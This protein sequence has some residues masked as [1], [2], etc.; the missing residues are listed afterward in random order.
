MSDI[1]EQIGPYKVGREI[2]RGG[3]GVVYLAHDTNLDRAV[4]IKTLPAEVT[5]D[6]ER[7]GRFEREAK[8]LAT[9]NHTNIAAV[10]GLE[11]LDGA[12]FLVL[13]YVAGETLSERLA[14]GPLP[15]DEA[16]SIALQIAQR[17]VLHHGG[18]FPRYAPSGHLVYVHQGT[19]Y[20][21]PLDLDRL[22]LTG[23]PGP[24]IEGIVS[25][26]RNGGAHYS[27]CDAG[28]LAY[29]PGS[30]TGIRTTVLTVDRDGSSTVLLDEETGYYSPSLSPTADRLALTIET[31]NVGDI[32][33]YEFE[34]E[35]LIRLTFDQAD[36]MQPV[37][38]PDGS[39]ILYSS[40]RETNTPNLFWKLSNGSGPA[41]RLTTSDNAQFASCISPDGKIVVFHERRDQTGG[42]IWTMPLEGDGMPELYLQTPFD[43]A[44]A[45]LSPDG[46]WLC[47]TSDESGMEQVYV[48]PFP[49]T[50][51]KWLVST[52][53][54]NHPLWGPAG[55]ELFYEQAGTIMVTKVTTEGPTFRVDRPKALFD[56]PF[57]FAPFFRPYDVSDDGLTFVLITENSDRDVDRTQITFVF[58][59]FEELK[60]RVPT[61]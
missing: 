4:A 25:N 23:S 40:T 54:G 60:Q 45:V 39:R 51:G 58:N 61:N 43:E 15:M 44:S 19:L 17:K 12:R 35:N 47:Y 36:D 29:Q 56:D 18:M 31:Q 21:A 24:I 1:P 50:G 28:T 52:D 6:A 30:S 32:W 13:A 38:T 3:M 53:G 5:G 37:W 59:W 7:L 20:A 27:F 57:V 14:E 22:E 55:D 48:R 9:L 11:K 49:D 46:R 41:E 16:L 10:F 8:L 33:V 2:G 42:D 26:P 34:R